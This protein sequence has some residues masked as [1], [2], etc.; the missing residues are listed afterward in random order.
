PFPAFSS[1]SLFV[2][3]YRASMHVPCKTNNALHYTLA[4]MEARDHGCDNALLLNADGYVCETAS[5]N[6]FWVKEGIL[7]TPETSLPFVPG[8]IRK[9]IIEHAPMQVVEGKFTLD[10]IAAADEIFM[11]NS[12]LLVAAITAVKPL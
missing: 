6:I 9:K 10:D 3:T 1:L 11:T 5:G 8:T 12:G 2:S 7:Y 4:M